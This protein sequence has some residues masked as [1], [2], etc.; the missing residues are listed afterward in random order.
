MFSVYL[1]S[2][3]KSAYQYYL[4]FLCTVNYLNPALEFIVLENVA[5]QFSYPCILDLK[6][7]TRQHGDDTPV[8]KRERIMAKVESSTSKTLGV[9]ACGLQV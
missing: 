7:G 3:N 5:Y 6:M 8:D 9:R 1:I 4:I 2:R